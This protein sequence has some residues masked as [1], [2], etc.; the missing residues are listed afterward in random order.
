MI[1][2]DVLGLGFS[3][4]PMPHHC[5]VFEQA[6]IMEALLQYLGLQTHEVHLLFHDYEIS[7]LRGCSIGLSR[8]DLVGLS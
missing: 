7:F 6:G 8:I 4:K 5:S 1:A 3:D 2:L